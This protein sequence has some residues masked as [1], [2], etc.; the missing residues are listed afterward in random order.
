[1]FSYKCPQTQFF[2]CLERKQSKE[3]EKS[4]R[5]QNDEEMRSIELCVRGNKRKAFRKETE[6]KEA[7]YRAAKKQVLD[8]LWLA[9]AAATTM[10][11][12]AGVKAGKQ[13][14]CSTPTTNRVKKSPHPPKPEDNTRRTRTTKVQLAKQS[15][16]DG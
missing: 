2:S 1:M 7:R 4:V 12:A 9:A 6:E 13:E 3:K 11:A 15:K 8:S 16:A 10:A 5:R 14:V